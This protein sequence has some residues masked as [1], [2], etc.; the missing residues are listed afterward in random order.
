MQ[1]SCQRECPEV[2]GYPQGRGVLRW[3]PVQTRNIVAGHRHAERGRVRNNV[4]PSG[5]WKLFVRI[6]DG[7]IEVRNNVTPSGVWKPSP[8]AGL[9]LVVPVR[10]NVTPS[11]V[12]KPATA[13]RAY[14]IP[15]RNNVTPSGV[16]KQDAH[17]LPRRPHQRVRNNVTPSG[18]WKRLHVLGD[19]PLCPSPSETTSRHQAY[20]NIRSLRAGVAGTSPKQRHAIRRMETVHTRTHALSPGVVRNN[21]TPSGVWKPLGLGRLVFVFPAVRNNVTPSGVWKPIHQLAP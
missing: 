18:V 19:Q 17:R 2:A 7:R 5:V 15:V 4:T 8:V 16:W 21:V 12:W 10:N 20:G 1:G 14:A 9:L 11:G 3:G 6:R 13:L